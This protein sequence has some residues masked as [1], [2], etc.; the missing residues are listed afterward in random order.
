MMMHSLCVA[1]HSALRCALLHTHSRKHALRTHA[2]TRTHSTRTRTFAHNEAATCRA[3]RAVSSPPR[4]YVKRLESDF[5]LQ[6]RESRL[7]RHQ[8]D[9]EASTAAGSDFGHG[10]TSIS[11]SNGSSSSRNT[12]TT[13]NNNNNALQPFRSLANCVGPTSHGPSKAGRRPMGT[14][15]HYSVRA[16][17]RACG[18]WRRGYAAGPRK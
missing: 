13:T 1:M 15:V 11:T 6:S 8:L 9:L 17:V 12:I 7:A 18:L 4:R 5:S 2:R 16:C 14:C 10:S 3:C